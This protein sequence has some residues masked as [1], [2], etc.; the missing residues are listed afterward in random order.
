MSEACTMPIWERSNSS[1]YFLGGW[2]FLK[3][4]GGVKKK[5]L[6]G[7]GQ[8]LLYIG[9]AYVEDPP[10]QFWKESND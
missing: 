3:I 6:V 1:L 9:L 4:E 5:V 10:V 8:E 2:V 7:G